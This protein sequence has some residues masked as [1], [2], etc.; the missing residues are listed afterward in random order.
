[1][2]ASSAAL[3]LTTLMLFVGT[4]IYAF[5]EP[6]RAAGTEPALCRGWELCLPS[7]D[8]DRIARRSALILAGIF[9]AAISSL[10]SIL[11]LSD[12]P[13]PHS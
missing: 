2:I 6:M 13:V 11:A 1:M 8:C 7:M 3:L 5:Y 12:H 10:D 4:A 9:A